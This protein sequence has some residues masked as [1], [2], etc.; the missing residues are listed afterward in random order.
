VH[1]KAISQLESSL[2]KK[3]WRHCGRG[4]KGDGDEFLHN[5][6]CQRMPMFVCDYKGKVGIAMVMSEKN[7]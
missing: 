4:H 5:C 1:Q 7:C 2:L 6:Q 3:D